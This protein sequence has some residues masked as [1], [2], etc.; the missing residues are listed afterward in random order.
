M[1]STRTRGFLKI[2]DVWFEETRNFEIENKCDFVQYH[3]MRNPLKDVGYTFNETHYKTI[4]N[5]LRETEQEIMAH[6]RSNVRNEVRRAQKEGF[7][8]ES[9]NSNMLKTDISK[10]VDF[11]NKYRNMCQNKGL[12]IKSQYKT[13]LSYVNANALAVTV[14]KLAT[15]DCVYHVYVCDSENFTMVRLLHSVSVFRELKVNV[16]RSAIAR[17]NRM[18]HYED[19][20]YF[21]RLGYA[22]YDWGGYSEK[23]ELINIAEFKAG[24]GGYIENISRYVFAFSRIAKIITILKNNLEKFY[25]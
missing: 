12:P 13:L 25:S 19:M 7:Q 9:F 20:L 3:D 21:K 10:I 23:P 5:D 14:A 24:F 11:D 16:E 1:I 22:K 8:A 2:C 18:L 6:F 17:A 4:I 15:S